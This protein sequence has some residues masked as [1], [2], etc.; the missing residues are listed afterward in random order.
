MRTYRLDWELG[1]VR[2]DGNALDC[3]VSHPHLKI[4]ASLWHISW[5]S[6]YRTVAWLRLYKYCWFSWITDYYAWYDF[7]HVSNQMNET[8][9][10]ALHI[11]WII[12]I[13]HI[14]GFLKWLFVRVYHPVSILL[15]MWEMWY[16]LFVSPHPEVQ[17]GRWHL[18]LDFCLQME[19]YICI[20]W[21]QWC[22]KGNE[23]FEFWL[24][25]LHSN[26]NSPLH[27]LGGTIVIAAHLSQRTTDPKLYSVVTSSISHLWSWKHSRRVSQ[28]TPPARFHRKRQLIA[29]FNFRFSK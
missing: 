9:Y 27:T 7:E 1:D 21:Y 12:R 11:V 26:D 14:Y 6:S 15:A 18:Y 16:M 13:V 8:N 23:H 17:D 10:S 2:G 24:W 28:E 3:L 22:M 29:N 25:M 5:Y 19:A 20:H 4:A